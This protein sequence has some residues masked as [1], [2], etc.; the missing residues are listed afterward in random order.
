VAYFFFNSHKL[1][2][3]TI[4]KGSID[5]ESAPDKNWPIGRYKVVLM[6]NHK[7]LKELYF[8]IR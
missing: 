7:V 6:Q 3:W 1:K 2:N 8:N 4:E 5:L